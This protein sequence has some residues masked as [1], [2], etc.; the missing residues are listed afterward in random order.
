MIEILAVMV[1]VAIL[2]AGWLIRRQDAGHRDARARNPRPEPYLD[3][4]WGDR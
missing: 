1:I 2:L 3:E 4:P